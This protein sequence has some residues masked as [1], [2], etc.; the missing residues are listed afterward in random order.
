[1]ILDAAS[2]PYGTTVYGS[3]LTCNPSF[4][5]GVVFK[6]APNP[7]GR[8]RESVLHSSAGVDG[9][10]PAGGVILDAASNLYGTTYCGGAYGRGDLSCNTNLAGYGTVFKLTPTSSGWSETVVHSFLGYGKY[11]WAPVILDRAGDLYGTTLNGSTNGAVV[12][13]ITREGQ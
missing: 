4:G 8:W 1:V 12:F 7:D 3:D 13:K 5:C 11:P 2:N 9:A 10:L 6:L